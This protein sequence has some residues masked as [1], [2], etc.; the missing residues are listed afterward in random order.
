MGFRGGVDSAMVGARRAA[1]SFTT[2]R[3]FV[4]GGWTKTVQAFNGSSTGAFTLAGESAPVGAPITAI[5]WA[6]TGVYALS[7]TAVYVFTDAA[8]PVLVA[9]Y[10]VDARQTANWLFIYGAYLIAPIRHGVVVLNASTGVEIDRFEGL[11]S[12]G[13]VAAL[14]TLNGRLYLLEAARTT[15]T[16]MAITSSG[17]LTDPG[18]PFA[19]PNCRDLRGALVDGTSLVVAAADRVVTFSLADVDNPT[20]VSSTTYTATIND[21]VFL[22]PGKY[23]V[24]TDPPLA[25]EN[26]P[27]PW[28]S[29]GGVLTTSGLTSVHGTDSA[30]IG[31]NPVTALDG[32]IVT[33]A[34]PS[35]I[36]GLQFNAQVRTMAVM[37]DTIYLGGDFTSVTDASG[38]KTRNYLCAVSLVTGL[39]TGFD[40]NMN[41]IVIITRFDTAGRLWVGGDFTTVGGLTRARLAMFNAD[42]T[43]NAF[44]GQADGQVYGIAFGN[45]LAYI[46]GQFNNLGGSAR[47][48]GGAFNTTTLALDTLNL[49]ASGGSSGVGRRCL[50]SAA[51]DAYYSGDFTSPTNGVASFT[52]A[53]VLRSFNP[54]LSGL[55]ATGDG[56]AELQSLIYVGGDFTSAGGQS[57]NRIAAFDYS[58]TLQPFSVNLNLS[59]YTIAIDPVFGVIYAG[60]NFT[61]AN[62][63][64][65]HFAAAFDT[66]GNLTSWDAGLTGGS[67]VYEF[68]FIAPSVFMCGAFTNPAG[69]T[70]IYVR[71]R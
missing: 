37:G 43:L 25:V 20:F 23:W 28:P 24:A 45:G 54:Q 31:Q 56:M 52:S 53:G 6:P 58:G 26:M 9:T 47:A 4:V 50:V 57:R 59:C 11:T 21:L 2:G 62:S 42:F 30:L 71:G 67:I 10:A 61:Q 33:Y 51:G 40:P 48:K 1:F 18:A 44:D 39:V 66:A 46:G 41:G 60:G 70:N 13:T 36:N 34:N 17:R 55:S 14:D 16:P 15:G 5:T 27:V 12:R 65:R 19:L 35:A 63:T 32:S 69:G 22:A 7:E 64:N 49:S 68:L 29:H 8:V 38:T 3:T